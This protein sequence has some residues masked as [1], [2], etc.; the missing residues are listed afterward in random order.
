MVLPSPTAARCNLDWSCRLARQ[1]PL[2]LVFAGKAHPHDDAGKALI[3]ALHV[4]LQVLQPDVPD[5]FLPNYDMRLARLL[6]VG[7]DV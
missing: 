2:Q 1:W 4:H 7:A 5:V 6:V 3:R